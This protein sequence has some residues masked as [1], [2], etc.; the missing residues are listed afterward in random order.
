VFRCSLWLLLACVCRV[1]ESVRGPVLNCRCTAALEVAN[2]LG[3]GLDRE[4]VEI[5][6]NLLELGVNADA[7]AAVVREMKREGARVRR[8]VAV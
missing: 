4:S 6:L 3:C 1:C 2:I 7:L 5:L 8:D